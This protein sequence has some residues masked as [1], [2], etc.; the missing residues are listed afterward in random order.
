MKG[1]NHVIELA[2]A[3]AA[4]FLFKRNLRTTGPVA[5]IHHQ[6][7]ARQ[8]VRAEA[9]RV[10]RGDVVSTARR[11]RGGA[12]GEGAGVAGEGCGWGKLQN[13]RPDPIKFHCNML[14]SVLRI[15]TTDWPALA[16]AIGMPMI[17]VISAL[18]PR[19]F[20]SARSP[21]GLL[22]EFGLPVALACACLLA[23]RCKRVLDLFRFGALAAG[24][25]TSVQF[26][27]DRGRIGFRYD[28]NGVKYQSWQPVHQTK[29]V[30]E[31]EIGQQVQVLFDPQKPGRAVVQQLF[32]RR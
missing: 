5:W 12:G 14:P 29:R 2:A 4:E 23:W 7:H 10:G 17:L 27:K 1:N 28:L 19:A 11:T 18:Y 15:V 3:A 31:L 24:E 6:P 26:S 21:W 8:N 30:L 13:A 32:E 22:L 25:I 9:G 16:A 20:P